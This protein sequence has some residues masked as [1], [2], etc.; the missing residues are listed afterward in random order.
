[1][2]LKSDSVPRCPAS[3]DRV[4]ASRVPRRHRYYQSTTT[5]CAEYGVAYVFRF[6]APTDPLLVR[7]HAVERSAGPGPAR[8]RYHWLLSAGH[9][10]DLPGSWRI[11]P[12]PLPRSRI[13]ASSSDLTLS[14]RQCRPH[15]ADSEGTDF[16]EMSRLN[17]AASVPAA[18]ASNGALPHPHARLASGQWL[19]LAGRESN[20]LDSIEKFPSSTSDFL[21]SQIYPG[22]TAN[23]PH[24]RSCGRE[25][26][27]KYL[28]VLVERE[29][30]EPHRNL[31]NSLSFLTFRNLNTNKRYH[32]SG[33]LKRAD[34]RLL[35]RTRVSPEH[36]RRAPLT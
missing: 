4:R 34:L 10:Q 25:E 21:L 20:P 14:V 29:G 13:P 19:A 27:R 16:T 2:F 35:E 1:V 5:S 7:S 22:A 31:L 11:H 28:I 36:A 26:P 18:Y 15:F 8:A 32:Q 9:T 6:S 3:L 30:L 23:L 24:C 12:V 33:E 17:H